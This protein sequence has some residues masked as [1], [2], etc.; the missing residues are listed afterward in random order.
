MSEERWF[1]LRGGEASLLIDVAPA[2][3]GLPRI[4]HWGGDL[5]DDPDF[6]A[7]VAALPAPLW[8]AR[9]DVPCPPCVLPG[10]E[11]GYFGLP[12]LAPQHTQGWSFDGVDEDDD[13]FTLRLALQGAQATRIEIDYRLSDNGVLQTRT[14]A[15]DLPDGLT[16][17]A[18]L[19]LPLPQW[20]HEVM[21]FGGDWAREFAPHRQ[22]LANGALL[23]ESRRGRPGH[24]RFPA[25]IAGSPQ[26]GDDAGEVYAVTL[27]WSGS[28]RLSVER[29]REGD[30]LVQAGEL[31]PD[32]DV[33]DDVYESPWA[34]A[35]YSARGLNGAMQTMHAFQRSQLLPKQV[36]KKPRLVHLNTWE[37]VYFNHD[38]DALRALATR[39]A[40]LGVERF[41]LDDGWFK[42]RANDRAG[43]G[44]WI[45]DREKFP[46]GLTPLIDHVR[47]LGMEFGLWVEPEMV[48]PDSDLARGHPHWLRRE[49][50]GS[51]LL[52]RNQAV[53][54]LSEPELVEHL[55][56]T[57]NTLLTAHPIS[58]LKWDMNRD[59]TGIS[60]SGLPNHGTYVRAIYGLIDR[61]RA[62][63]PDVEIEACASGGGRADWGMLARS[64][65]VWTSDSNDALDRFEIQ[66]VASL[67]LPLEVMGAHIGPAACHITGRRLSL[68]LRAHVA[69]FGHMGLELDIRALSETEGARLK[70]HLANYKRFRDLL[71]SGRLWRMSLN[72]PDHG[73]LGVTSADK[74]QALFLLLRCSS[75]ELGRGTNLWFP[76]L[77]ADAEYRITAVAPISPSGEQCLSPALRA[78]DL[79]LSGTVLMTRGLDL[80]LPRPES[81][82]LLHL[83]RV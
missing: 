28:H 71:H 67:F 50:D 75:H 77:S 42:G 76:G 56:E 6:E 21:T 33:V 65:R 38:L 12:A 43:L 57:L 11:G 79:V 83:E 60:R 80:F 2:G 69:M 72:D 47:R 26:F 53:L 18:A 30:V 22:I 49:A 10:M 44:D 58:Y 78:G 5:G 36:S 15:S 82:L 34:F 68:D 24:D 13:G 29:L 37:A 64:E 39:A 63:H 9:L 31:M 23:L 62:A 51:L 1:Y 46:D 48:N 70:S 25:L 20:A 27:G 74:R 66:R 73:A 19:A 81:S 8:G 40:E 7:I 61:L 3:G 41:V 45:P 17:I 54:D 52:Q 4:V 14:R 55:Y 32:G 59:L 16:W 35:A